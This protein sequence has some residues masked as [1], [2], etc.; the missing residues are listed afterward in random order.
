MSFISTSGAAKLP[1]VLSEI[2]HFSVLLMRLNS[3]CMFTTVSSRQAM[4][5]W[6]A[7]LSSGAAEWPR[8]IFEIMQWFSSS[9]AA[10]CRVYVFSSIV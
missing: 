5:V 7:V 10:G 1:R 8:V 3:A 9:D 4:F 2:M 6:N